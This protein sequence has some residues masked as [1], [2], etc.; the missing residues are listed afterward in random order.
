M[1]FQLSFAGHFL[2][3]FALQPFFPLSDAFQSPLYASPDKI[4]VSFRD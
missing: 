3:D 4:S 2:L 1:P